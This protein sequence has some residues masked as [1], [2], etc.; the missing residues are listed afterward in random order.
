MLIIKV[1]RWGNI[2]V[3]HALGE[4]FHLQLYF[5][6]SILPN[7]YILWPQVLSACVK[8]LL[9]HC[10]PSKLHALMILGCSMYNQIN[11]HMYLAEKQLLHFS[12]G[13]LSASVPDHGYVGQA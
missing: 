6:C 11:R 10:L 3:S 8:S 4:H 9:C 2:L 13:Y 7:K 5:L 12:E 1:T